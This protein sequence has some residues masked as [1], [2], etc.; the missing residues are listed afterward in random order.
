[1]AQPTT[2]RGQG[3]N[4]VREALEAGQALTAL[5]A[6]HRFGVQHL[7]S[8]IWALKQKGMAIN[9]Q[10]IEVLN[11]AGESCYVALYSLDPHTLPAN[12]VA[13]A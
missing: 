13:E 7:A 12:A 10:R 11:R 9:S 8:T 4:A 1:M 3:M 6:Y 5:D 2:T